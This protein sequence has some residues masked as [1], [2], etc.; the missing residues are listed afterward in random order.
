[1]KDKI[2]NLLKNVI[3]ENAV[4]VKEQTN[5]ALYQKV[6]DRLKQEYVNV[7]RKLFNNLHEDF[8]IDPTSQTSQ[9][10]Q[11][12]Q[13]YQHSNMM[14]GGPGAGGAPGGKA[15]NKQGE[16][17]NPDP[18]PRPEN[19]FPNGLPKEPKRDQFP[20]GPE[21]DKQFVEALREW[22]LAIE[23]WKEYQKVLKEWIAKHDDWLYKQRQSNDQKKN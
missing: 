5:N 17:L 20:K 18:G 23:R 21:G 10:F 13:T 9:T 8:S 22:R 2:Q 16:N 4:R 1:M 19:P 6:G 12:S 14:A 11:T 15:G 7:S 3:E